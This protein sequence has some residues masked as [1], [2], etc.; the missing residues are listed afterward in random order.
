MYIHRNMS[1]HG[2]ALQAL[3]DALAKPRD[4][5]P[6]AALTKAI[7]AIAS[8]QRNPIP[9]DQFAQL[10]V[11]A[12][13]TLDPA[14]ALADAIR[15][16]FGQKPYQ[17][18][19]TMR[20]NE[21]SGRTPY[22]KTRESRRPGFMRPYR[23]Y[24]AE[25]IMYKWSVAT[26]QATFLPIL[27][28]ITLVHKCAMV[29]DIYMRGGGCEAINT[30]A[31]SD[32]FGHFIVAYESLKGR[33][34]LASAYTYMAVAASTATSASAATSASD[35]LAAAN[36]ADRA[37]QM[38]L[39]YLGSHTKAD[40]VTAQNLPRDSPDYTSVVR[41]NLDKLEIVKRKI[42]CSYSMPQIRNS[43][44]WFAQKKAPTRTITRKATPYAY[45]DVSS[46]LHA[47]SRTPSGRLTPRPFSAA[48]ASGAHMFRDHVNNESDSDSDSSS[49]STDTSTYTSTSTSRTNSSSNVSITPPVS[50]IRITI[51]GGTVTINICD[52]SL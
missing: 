45:G 31:N 2:A 37:H 15:A 22:G 36:A 1:T 9:F 6:G 19:V 17:Y 39:Y 27:E 44:I 12:L 30:A 25:D 38:T 40:G 29:T 16:Y 4:N 21:Y 10:Y 13:N 41:A 18:E 47:Q 23:T 48:T 8:Q 11:L 28:E 20:I 42:N 26:M 14:S 35:P 7:V 32:N 33:P 46:P 51:T 50:P 49:T 34:Y 43:E 3:A 52:C 24:S 5:K